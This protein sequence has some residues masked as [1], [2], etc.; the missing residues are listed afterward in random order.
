M[1]LAKT[2]AQ[3]H[4]DDA[5]REQRQAAADHSQHHGHISGW[6]RGARRRGLVAARPRPGAA[7]NADAAQAHHDDASTGALAAAAYVHV[8]AAKRARARIVVV[9]LGRV[10]IVCRAWPWPG[11]DKPSA[12]STS[13]PAADVTMVLTV[14]G[15]CLTLFTVSTWTRVVGSVGKGF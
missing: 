8:V 11:R 1:M 9:R 13:P 5:H 7:H 2:R 3:A 14:V 10:S 6:R 12:P 4:H 15:S